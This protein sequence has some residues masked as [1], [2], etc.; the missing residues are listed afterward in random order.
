MT[1]T[2]PDQ[3][4][5]T[6]AYISRFRSS[7]Y[8]EE[9]V[10]FEFSNSNDDK[11]SA[12]DIFQ[13]IKP[14]LRIQESNPITIAGRC[15]RGIELSKPKK[16]PEGNSLP[17]GIGSMLIGL[18]SAQSQQELGGKLFR[19]LLENLDIVSRFSGA[20]F[21]RVLIKLAHTYFE[22]SVDAGQVEQRAGS[23]QIRE[24]SM[25]N[26]LVMDAVLKILLVPEADVPRAKA[27]LAAAL[28]GACIEAKDEA[29][30]SSILNRF[31]ESSLRLRNEVLI[32]GNYGDQTIAKILGIEPED[33]R[34]RER[35]KWFYDFSEYDGKF[36]IG[37]TELK[38]GASFPDYYQYYMHHAE[39]VHRFVRTPVLHSFVFMW[40]MS[41]YTDYTKEKRD[42]AREAFK[43]GV[44]RAAERIYGESDTDRKVRANIAAEEGDKVIQ[45]N[46]DGGPKLEKSV[47]ELRD[48]LA[49]T[50]TNE[51]IKVFDR[52]VTF[53]RRD[54]QEYLEILFVELVASTSGPLKQVLDNTREFFS[55]FSEF[56]G[57]LLR[58]L[59]VNEEQNFEDVEKIREQIINIDKNSGKHQEVLCAVA[60]RACDALSKGEDDVK[61]KIL[62]EFS[63]L[64]GKSSLEF[65]YT[66]FHGEAEKIEKQ[67]K[68]IMDTYRA[69]SELRESTREVSAE[70]TPIVAAH[71]EPTM[72]G[73]G[74]KF[75]DEFKERLREKNFKTKLAVPHSETTKKA[76]A[77]LA[78]ESKGND[79]IPG[80]I[81][82]PI[83]GNISCSDNVIA[84]ATI[85]E[86]S[87][88][89][90][91]GSDFVKFKN[92]ESGAMPPLKI[93]IKGEFDLEGE[94]THLI[95]PAI[96]E[97][98][99][100][101]VRKPPRSDDE[102]EELFQGLADFA[103][104]KERLREFYCEG[105]KSDAYYD[106]QKKMRAYVLGEIL[107]VAPDGESRLGVPDVSQSV[108]LILDLVRYVGDLNNPK[109]VEP[110]PDEDTLTALG[111]GTPKAQFNLSYFFPVPDIDDGKSI[112][113][114]IDYH[115]VIC[116]SVDGVKDYL[117]D[118]NDLIALS[119]SLPTRAKLIVVNSTLKEYID[120]YSMGDGAVLLPQ[121]H[122]PSVILVGRC[123][124][125]ES[126]NWD[127]FR[128]G[129]ENLFSEK[130][131][132]NSEEV[133]S[134][135]MIVGHNTGI[136]GGC[137]FPFVDLG[138]LSEIGFIPTETSFRRIQ[139]NPRE[140]LVEH[141]KGTRVMSIPAAMAV[142]PML[143][144]EDIGRF[145]S[146]MLGMKT[147][148][149][150]KQLAGVSFQVDSKGEWVVEFL[151][152]CWRDSGHNTA[153]QAFVVARIATLAL[154]RKTGREMY[155]GEFHNT[156][157]GE[158]DMNEEH[159]ALTGVG[160]LLG[161]DNSPFLQFKLADSGRRLDEVRQKKLFGNCDDEIRLEIGEHKMK[162]PKEM[163]ENLGFIGI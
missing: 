78:G 71:L 158:A 3:Y 117:A 92:V 162:I 141:A 41:K 72:V 106:F 73:V 9:P 155:Y 57:D 157:F 94:G 122:H 2:L 43:Y 68:K 60:D 85:S 45:L 152:R 132:R 134:C 101:L 69:E 39:Q 4:A 32:N 103:D 143:Q 38:P 24:L 110:N 112:V 62:N 100:D 64:T 128:L 130:W 67:V 33:K 131:E 114:A 90:E 48:H 136:L 12:A 42:V 54:L 139:N 160:D 19:Q 125:A 153:L 146:G 15:Y 135:P 47:E 55:K 123:G 126:P 104:L 46:K 29:G 31:V 34:K 99:D 5:H 25:E 6:V 102:I 129:F 127:E 159:P 107:Q 10:I 50:M 81:N 28:K 105:E 150:V 76:L 98:W 36:N 1:L 40:L 84:D 97:H 63:R 20:E 149:A 95:D 26:P 59:H 116:N 21:G 66:R 120:E 142:T 35:F 151:R 79:E 8:D 52:K 163:L 27:A 14:E 75:E 83:L 56:Y 118:I 13:R 148:Q 37:E 82:G 11:L 109:Q 115:E 144:R 137:P 58:I 7:K 80:K 156:F 88:V 140:L 87:T 161:L 51:M 86:D 16:N 111:G 49:V 119:S 93:E 138:E 154:S 74:P 96:Q 70:T 145:P 30:R 108:R 121:S 22:N 61:K 18:D 65:Y 147:R 23:D 124:D 17:L 113:P 91:F 53:H 133:L 89:V 77:S 44:Q